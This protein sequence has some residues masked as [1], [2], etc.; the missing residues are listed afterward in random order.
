MNDVAISTITKEA[1][2]TEWF[3]LSGMDMSEYEAKRGMRERAAN[4]VSEAL[5]KGQRPIFEL[6]TGGGKTIIA[7][8]VSAKKNARTLFLAPSKPLVDQHERFLRKEMGCRFHS[9]VIDGDT[10]VSERIWS[11]SEERFIFATA[12]VVLAEMKKGVAILEHFT[13]VTF[14]EAHHGRGLHADIVLANIL[15]E[16]HIPYLG[17]SA[18]LGT[19]EDDIGKLCAQ[20]HFDVVFWYGINMPTRREEYI[21]LKLSAAQ[22]RTE[23]GGFLPLHNKLK[24]QLIRAL[25]RAR[26]KFPV[27]KEKLF[28]AKE[29]DLMTARIGGLAD[30]KERSICFL[31]LGVYKKFLYAYRV[32]MVEGFNTFL[33]Y[34]NDMAERGEKS[35]VKLLSERLFGR[36]VATARKEYDNHPKEQRLL[37]EI[38]R[39]ARHPRQIIT[40]FANMQ[41]A[42]HIA[43]C[44]V[45]KGISAECMFG[46]RGMRKKERK[47]VMQRFIQGET[48]VLLA[49]SVIEEGISVPEVSEVINAN[50]ATSARSRLQRAGRTARMHPGNVLHLI[51]EH[52]F[53]L[54]IFYAV[55]RELKNFTSNR[56]TLTDGVRHVH[57][58]HEFVF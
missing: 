17:L 18:S 13:L 41:S 27:T 23:E 16:K 10:K 37:E 19:D 35:D 57:V 3:T 28:T 49:T 38:A 53:D 55:H 43:K 4:E 29:L 6:A 50:I 46:A 7:M 30:D 22:V 21:F 34:V 45:K 24:A 33:S 11:N 54:C 8:L 44:A 25:L 48:R 5:T 9:R 58:Q 20:M 15:R 51:M 56:K 32:F 14:D 12:E 47:I 39:G 1:V 52:D 42:R 31:F 26:V 40:F 2:W 36:I